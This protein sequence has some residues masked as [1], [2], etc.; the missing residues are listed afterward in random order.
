MN[1]P[2]AAKEIRDR[3]WKE[4]FIVGVTGN[5][6]PEDVQY[7]QSCGANAV[8]PKPVKMDE[9]NYLWIENGVTSNPTSIS[10]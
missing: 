7:F 9:L 2:D 10:V 1:G 3:G 6:L 4:L 8:L 5:L